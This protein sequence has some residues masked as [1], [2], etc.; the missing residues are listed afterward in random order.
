MARKKKRFSKSATNL[1]LP[2]PRKATEARKRRTK[3]LWATF[4]VLMIA[5]LWLGYRELSSSMNIVEFSGP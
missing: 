5:I 3:Y 2:G 4:V 1:V